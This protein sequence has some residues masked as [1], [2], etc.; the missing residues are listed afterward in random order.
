MIATEN[1]VSIESTNNKIPAGLRESAK[2][3][4]KPTV[5][6]ASTVRE[7]PTGAEAALSGLDTQDSTADIDVAKVERIKAGI[8]DGSL[9]FSAE[10][11]ADGLV[12]SAS[13]L[14]SESEE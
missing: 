14:T 13:L 5:Q 11:I 4:P 3:T 10:R 2:P 8:A 12:E 7:T 1:T 9:S 6:T